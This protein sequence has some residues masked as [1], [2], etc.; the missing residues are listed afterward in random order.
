MSFTDTDVKQTYQGNGATTTFAI[1]F[2][3]IE[4]AVNETKVYIRDESTDEPTETLKTYSTHYTISGSNVVF[5]TAPASTEV[6][7][8]YRELPLTQTLDLQNNADFVPVSQETALDRIVAMAQQI[9]EK[10]DR[11]PK[12]LIGDDATLNADYLLAINAQGTAITQIPASDINNLASTLG[13]PSYINFTDQASQVATPSSGFTRLYSGSDGKVYIVTSAGS[14]TLVGPAFDMQGMI[15]NM[16]VTTSVSSNAMTIALKNAAGSDASARSPIKIAFRNS[17]SATGTFN[18]RSVTAALSITIPSSATLGHTNNDP[19]YIYLCAI[20]N[21][22][23]VELGVIGSRYQLDE[24]SVVTTTTISASATASATMYSTTGRSNVPFR[25]L[26]RI[27]STQTTAGTWASNA[28]QI[29]LFQRDKWPDSSPWSTSGYNITMSAAF[30]TITNL[31]CRGKRV[32]DEAH[33]VGHLTYASNNASSAQM[34][35]PTNISIDTT[36]MDSRANVQKVG[37]WHQLDGTTANVWSEN[38][39]GVLT[40]DGSDVDNLFIT[41][42]VSSD[43][44]VKQNASVT[45]NATNDFWFEF[46]IPVKQWR[47]W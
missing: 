26:A 33:I 13:S 19:C 45:F 11:A 23:T 12:F 6:V 35:L 20:D 17:T 28:S 40:F 8:I 7:I 27:K 31:F 9:N 41:D 44:F 15:T 37:T 2:Q 29:S 47:S 25:I 16:S 10:V 42:A 38:I 30:G 43:T 3:V 18:V 39:G 4:S 34:S 46:W 32:Q 24:G 1:P 5:N 21:S 36:K 14:E 22:G